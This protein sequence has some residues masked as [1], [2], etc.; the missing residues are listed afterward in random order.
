MH[1]QDIINKI[2]INRIIRELLLPKL[3]GFSIISLSKYDFIDL[4]LLSALKNGRYYVY[5]KEIDLKFPYKLVKANKTYKVYK[6]IPT[7]TKVYFIKKSIFDVRPK[8]KAD[9]AI[10]IEQNYNKKLHNRI[11]Q[12]AKHL[13]LYDIV[14]DK[15]KCIKIGIKNIIFENLYCCYKNRKTLVSLVGFYEL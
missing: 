12:L 13:I 11:K 2:I 3:D 5:N 4:F 10:V 1:C 7:N 8:E 15:K 14:Y 6:I 9:L